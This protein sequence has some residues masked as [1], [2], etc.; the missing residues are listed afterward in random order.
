MGNTAIG[1]NG[2]AICFPKNK[3]FAELSI[4]KRKEMKFYQKSGW[5][6]L[7]TTYYNYKPT[8]SLEKCLESTGMNGFGFEVDNK[9]RVPQ[10]KKRLILK[11]IRTKK[12][13]RSKK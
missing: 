4:L 13:K 6:K 2:I 1:G 8:L 9:K 12:N 11:K 7:L 3:A 10:N 5:K